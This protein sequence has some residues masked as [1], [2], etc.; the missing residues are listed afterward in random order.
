MDNTPVPPVVPQ[1]APPG[2]VRITPPDWNNKRIFALLWPLVAEQFLIGS[3]GFV[4]MLMA[5]HVGEY[6]VSAISLV[7]IINFLFIA[8]FTALATG[9]AVVASQYIGR[10]DRKNACCSARQLVYISIAVS[11]VLMIFI[12]VFHRVLLRVIYGNIAEDVM[13]AA[14]TYFF[15]SALSFPFIAL[16]SAAAALFRSMGISA[17]NMRIAF[18]V[19]V[20]NIAGNIFF[21]HGLGFGAEGPA[22]A[23]LI[24][25]FTAAFILIFLL[26]RN[27]SRIIDI[28]GITNIKFEPAMIKRILNIGIPSGLETSMFQFGKILIARIFTHFG[29]A[30]I[31]G[32]GAATAILSLSFFTSNA[33]IMGV[34]TIVGQCI[35]AGDYKAA[36]LNTKK[37]I[38]ATYILYVIMNLFT[39]VF[40]DR[41]IGFFNLSPEAH[42][43]AAA[44]ILIHLIS[45]T[46]FFAPSFV[47]PNAL[48]AAGDVRYV[49]VVAASTMWIV[50]VSAAFIMA[51]PLGLGPHAAWLA[52][53][54]DFVF[55][56]FF[57]YIRWI[58][59]RWMEK[60][61]I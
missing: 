60:R 2:V 23:T 59:G 3:M 11:I 43:L 16:Y 40:K 52:M 46:L 20:L 12:L 15:I 21:I 49:M 37:L 54:T 45:S 24:G 13:E 27:S 58:R 47:L 51:F 25:R 50:R 38:T 42:E 33:F 30:A 5:G 6:A 32:N 31:A 55:R 35:G 19:N 44:F 1:T 36:K 48:R 28:R 22:L 4:N 53:G 9:G 26:L 7:E 34:V 57:F 10:G 41:F 61:V 39:F 56:S 18:L 29:T 17:I 14:Q 8:A